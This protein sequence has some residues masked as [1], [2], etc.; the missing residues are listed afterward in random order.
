[1]TVDLAIFWFVGILVYLA[2]VIIAWSRR[3]P[4]A[5]AIT[6]LDVLL[7]WLVLPWVIALIWATS[8]PVER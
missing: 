8:A 7:G 2:P 5:V 4:S 6:L 1:M 3:H